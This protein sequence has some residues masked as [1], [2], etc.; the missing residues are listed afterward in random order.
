[1]NEVTSVHTLPVTETLVAYETTKELSADNVLI[2]P[3]GKLVKVA[4][5]GVHEDGKPYYAS[6]VSVEETLHALE[7]FVQMIKQQQLERED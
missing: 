7:T 5:V 3:I 6:N 4:L 1:M 2:Y